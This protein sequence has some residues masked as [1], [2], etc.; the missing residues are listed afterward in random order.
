MLASFI[1][2]A[3]ARVG[4]TAAAAAAGRV[5]VRLFLMLSM[6]LLFLLLA[7][8]FLLGTAILNNLLHSRH[9]LRTHLLVSFQSF[10]AHL[11]LM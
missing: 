7:H 2:I 5:A 3:A 1:M 10:W 8:L 6:H 11:A 9:S 4:G